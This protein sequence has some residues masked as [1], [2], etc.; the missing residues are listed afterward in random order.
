MKVRLGLVLAAAA[1][2]AGAGC[3]ASG[4]GT[5]A[6]VGPTLPGGEVLE[7]GVSPRDNSHTRSADLNL[8][9]AQSTT[10]EVQAQQYFQDAMQSV[11]DGITADPGNPKSFFQGGQAAIGLGDYVAADTLFDKAEELHPRYLLETEGFREQGWVQ[12]YNDAIIPMN[13]GDLEAAAAA[14]EAATALYGDRPESLLQLG[15]IQARMEQADEAVAAFEQAMV[16]LE[17]TREIHLADTTTA[18]IWQQHWDIATS[19]LGQTLTYAERYDEAAELYTALLEE[20]PD[21]VAILGSLANVLSQLG[22][23]D[24]VQALYDQLLTRTDLGERELFNAGVGLYQIENYEQASSAFRR[25]AE[26][27]PFNRDARLNLAQTL[28]IG[29]DFEALIPAARDLLEVDPRNSLGW[30][31]LTRGL[32]ETDE[33]DQANAVFMEYQEIGYEV[34]DL[35]LMPDPNGGTRISGTV[36][37]TS[38]EAGTTISLRFHFGG[39]E[40]R[41]IGT[42]DIQIQAPGVEMSELFRGDFVST[43]IVTG[44]RY[45]VITP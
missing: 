16:L 34:A 8:T 25:A 42:L 19:S 39:A 27:N 38:I 18:E 6:P 43:E 29:E 23:P 11:V 32:S 36:K 15:S 26:M 33:T 21:D 37:N 44:Y 9:R 1:L 5:S 10:E 31:F 24:S 35:S 7:E 2:F 14:F 20:N 22:Q 28:S 12:A 3:T 45:E 17:E 13:N 40:G 4:G 41:E 30:I